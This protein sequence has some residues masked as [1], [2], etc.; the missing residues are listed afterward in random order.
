MIYNIDMGD[1]VIMTG[2]GM[3]KI[4]RGIFAACLA[5]LCINAAPPRDWAESAID[6]LHFI[7]AT[8]RENHPGPMDSENP[9]FAKWYDTG[10]VKALEKAK[11]ARDFAGYNFAVK[12]YTNG[13]QDGHLG[14][15]A[16]EP[17][18]EKRLTRHWPGF[19]TS[20]QKGIFTV[21]HVTPG[22]GELPMAGDELISCDGH[23]AAVI[24][25]EVIG[26]YSGLWSIGGLRPSLAPYLLVDEGN[27]FVQRPV[28]CLIRSKG[29]A[30]TLRL[31]W[32]PVEADDLKKMLQEDNGV[33][34]HHN[35]RR[36]GRNNYW[37]SIPS[38]AFNS[39]EQRSANQ[40]LL[41][42]IKQQA[43]ALRA[44]DRIVFDVRGNRGGSSAVGAAMLS[45]IWG[46]E[47]IEYVAPQAVA[48][49]WRVSAENLRILRSS[50]LESVKSQFGPDSPQAKEL[51]EL[52]SRMEQALEKGD[53]YYRE[54][55]AKPSFAK[56]EM[57]RA[58]PILLTDSSCGSA[59]LNFADIL[60]GGL[61]ALHVGAET[62]ADTV[63]IDNRVVRLPSGLGLFGF[64]MKVN[65]GRPRGNN[66]T[67][68]PTVEY[69][70]SMV[71]TKALQKW[72]EKLH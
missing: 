8:L 52:I 51:A 45:A 29:K 61:K 34:Q 36:F 14:A 41:D 40:S 66:V 53:L 24:A 9:A 63:Y 35:L 58:E 59:C 54:A 21:S 49:D 3:I 57:V 44:A 28:E 31:N 64:S 26:A 20:Y 65:R 39:E 56:P 12:Y 5:F 38:F 17:L 55:Y 62:R 10:F 13:F 33:Q 32:R 22:V 47:Y 43:V 16:E 37:I 15:L 23:P 11:Q 70:G 27:P 67:Y 69:K 25:E 68:R 42:A 19:L 18:D 30:R 4:K 1:K 72:I 2:G 50:N 6:D 48:V 71:D 7:R 60:I 46:Q